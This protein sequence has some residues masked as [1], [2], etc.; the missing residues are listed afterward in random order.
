MWDAVNM[1]VGM[2]IPETA[3]TQGGKYFWKNDREVPDMWHV[4][5]DYPKKDLAVTFAC[6]FH[7]RHVGEL[8][9]V[10]GRDLTLECAHEFCR[11]F[12]PD[13]KP[14]HYEKM[15]AARKLAAETRKAAQQLGVP[16]PITEVAPD[17]NFREGELKISSHMQNFF[18]CVRSRELPRC[19]V[20]RAF[21]EAVALIMSVEA[22]RREA[23][24]R[25][26]PVKEEI[27]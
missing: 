14:E 17:Y 26:D 2:G 23:K 7:N 5:F 22:Y 24:V 3:V 10:L 9:Q 4:L 19:H 16:A 6:S 1:V 27:M 25:W 18:D 21:E 11:T 13:W 12:T 8:I 15:M 20:D